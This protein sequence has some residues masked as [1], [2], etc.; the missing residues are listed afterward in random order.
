MYGRTFSRFTHKTTRFPI[1]T[2]TSCAANEN[3]PRMLVARGATASKHF[4]LQ[5]GVLQ[6]LQR[7]HLEARRSGLRRESFVFTRELFR[8]LLVDRCQSSRTSVQVIER[9]IDAR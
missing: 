8:A 9:L 4:R 2:P 6:L 5:R 1:A 3:A 7:A